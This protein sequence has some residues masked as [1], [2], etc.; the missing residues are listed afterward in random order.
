MWWLLWAFLA[1]EKPSN[2][3]HISDVEFE[4]MTHAQGDDVNDYEKVNIPL[5]SIL[6]SLPVAA[7]CLCQIAILWIRTLLLTNW[8]LYL[9]T[10]WGNIAE[11]GALA[12][13]PYASNIVMSVVS[14][15]LADFFLNQKYLTTTIVRKISIGVGF[16]LVCVGFL[17]LTTLSASLAVFIVLSMSI[18]AFGLA[19]SGLSVNPYNLSTRYASVLAAVTWTCGSI[20]AI[21]APIA[22]GYLTVKQTNKQTDTQTGR[23]TNKQTNT[24]TGRQTNKQTDTPTGRQMNKQT[25]TQT[26][27]QTN[28]QTDTRTG[29]QTNKQTDTQIGRQ[30]NK[31]TDSQTGRQTNK[32]TDTQTNR[33]TFI[34][35]TVSPFRDHAGWAHMFYLTAGII[36]LATI[37]YL[38]FGSGKHSAIM[39]NQSDA[40]LPSVSKEKR[41]INIMMSQMMMM[42]VAKW[43]ELSNLCQGK[44]R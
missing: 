17:V 38:I 31:Q 39:V 22:T 20:G 5:K 28:K 1:Y 33:L 24:Q 10:V 12:S 26:G 13:L 37:F 30:T 6:T 11:V 2:H 27:R 7:M 35:I 43:R 25:D 8:P 3:A 19:G 42:I 40:I 14:G 44:E 34:L 41:M 16:G 18:G 36:L 29:R 21:L 15:I 9:S 4:F 32:Q 23:Q